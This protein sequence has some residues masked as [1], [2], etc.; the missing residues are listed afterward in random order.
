MTPTICQIPFFF[1]FQELY[2]LLTK[3]LDK[4]IVFTA[5]KGPFTEINPWMLEA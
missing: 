5:W 2:G 4:N 3:I 1:F